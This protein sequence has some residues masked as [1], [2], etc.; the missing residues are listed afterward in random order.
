VKHC[1]EAFLGLST[2]A[3]QLRMGVVVREKSGWAPI[4]YIPE[5]WVY[6]NVVL[7]GDAA[8]QN[9][10]PFVEGIIPTIICGDLPGKT[11]SEY[12]RG[13]GSLEGSSGRVKAKLGTFF[14]EFDER[15]P[16]LYEGTKSLELRIFCSVSASLP[17]SLLRGNLRN[18][19][20]QIILQP[21]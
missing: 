21:S 6:G 8:H 1:Y 9:F 7:V 18:I 4:R 5:K 16:I 17:V 13:N 15:I 10:K 2:V 20:V 19:N 11:A 3:E 12:L 14:A